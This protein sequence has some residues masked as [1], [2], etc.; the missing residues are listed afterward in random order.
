ML[1]KVLCIVFNVL[2]FFMPFFLC[3]DG[4]DESWCMKKNSIYIT[5]LKSP[6][7]FL[8]WFFFV[9]TNK[10]QRCVNLEFCLHKMGYNLFLTSSSPRRRR[11]AHMENFN[12][13]LLPSEKHR[14]FFLCLS[15][16]VFFGILWYRWSSSI[17]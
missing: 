8:F 5:C 10:H 4:N 9:R 16:S 7:P 12:G 2:C 3:E 14:T 17:W 11:T 13:V 1:Y 6:Y 15:N